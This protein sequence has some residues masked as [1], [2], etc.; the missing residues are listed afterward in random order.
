M[1]STQGRTFFTTA[2]IFLLALLVLGMSMQLL[3][4][5]YLTDAAFEKLDNNSDALSRLAASYYADGS[6]SSMQFLMNLDLIATVSD[7]DAVICG[8]SGQI[9]ICSDFAEGCNHQE[10]TL[11]QDY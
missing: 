9:V 11:N 1:K 2:L 6:L 5:D 3:V 8:S 4:R 7:M 10:L